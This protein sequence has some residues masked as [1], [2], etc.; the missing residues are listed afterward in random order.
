LLF[1]IIDFKAK[2]KPK[3]LPNRSKKQKPAPK[4]KTP[5]YLT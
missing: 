4:N 1:E 5:C 3:E 2:A